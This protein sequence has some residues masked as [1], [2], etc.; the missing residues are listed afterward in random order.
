MLEYNVKPALLIKA[1]LELIHEPGEVFEVRIPKT[2]YGTISGY[3]NDPALAATT[4]AK[5]NGKYQAIYAT[6]NPIK[7]PLMARNESKLEFGSQLT[8]GDADIERRRWFLVDLDPVRAAGISSS[9]LELETAKDRGKSVKDWLMSLGWPEPIEACSGNGWHMMWRVDAPNDDDSRQIFEFALK[10]LAGIWSDDR[11]VVDTTVFNASRVWKIY[12]TISKKGSSTADRPHRIAS[13]QGIPQQ[14]E[15]VSLGLIESLARPLKEAKNE[16]YKDATG[17]YI[18]DMVKWLADRG[19][20]VTSGPRPMFGNEGQKW[21]IS[22]CPFNAE[23]TDPIVGLVNNRPVYKCLHNSCSAYRWKEFREQVDPTYK[24]PDVVYNR[25][26]EYLDSDQTEPDAELVA[27]AAALGKK[28]EGVYKRLRQECDRKRAGD[29]DELVRAERRRYLRDTIGENNEK[30]NIVGL[31]NRVRGYQ[32]SGIVPMFWIADYDHRVRVGKV[33]DIESRKASDFDEVNLLVR[34]H[35][36]GETWVKQTH[37]AQVI[38]Y[39]AEEYRVNPLKQH[40]KQFRWD[41]EKRL[42]TWLHH[43]LG[44][45]PG[46]YTAAIGRKWLISAVARA[47]EPGCQA[48]HMLILEGAQGIGKSQA[49]RIIGGQFYTEYSGGMTGAGTQHK[50]LVAVISGKLIIEMSELATVRRAEMES[51]KAILT[52]CVDDA[53]LSYER[54]AKPY[55]RTCVFGGTTNEVGQSYIADLTGA[56]RFWPC[57]VGEV[58]KP[59]IQLLR[60]DRD[61]LWA[62]AVEAYEGGEDWYTVPSEEVAEEQMD[63]QVSL[64]QSEPWFPRIRQM[65]TDSDAYSSELLVVQDRYVSGQ[66]QFGEHTVRVGNLSSILQIVL[67]LDAGRQSQADIQRL[68]RCLRS[69]GFK[70][71]RPSVKWMGGTYA[72]DLYKEA[73]PHLW[74]A[75]LAADKAAPNK[76]PVKA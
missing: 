47:F 21:V 68:Q 43:Y 19:V 14:L 74:D 44:A 39:T 66:H 4:I 56:R 30:G 8:T 26:K 18:Q 45:K 76:R 25:L 6:V 7:A 65:L 9:D 3:F 64:E 5:E 40:L 17:E 38:R 33:G 69:I 36:A 29:L 31:I 54:D 1:T 71:V 49:L 41:G 53:R 73:I 16:E 59:K 67:G 63:R 57:H 61:Q 23:H 11:V 75:I 55:P 10:M 42:D 35:S 48:D 52:T 22:R 62:E 58:H 13:L 50:D 51:L 72:Y 34:F 70:K 15:C 2:K 12:G 27:A 60:E 24:D 46:P 32:E 20:T 37:C 28:F